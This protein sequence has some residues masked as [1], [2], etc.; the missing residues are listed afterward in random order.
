MMLL[1]GVKT[2]Y[3][4]LDE[5]LYYLERIV[6]N[7]NYFTDVFDDI[8][9]YHATCFSLKSYGVRRHPSIDNSFVI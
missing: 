5:Y 7:D 4:K 2:I 9:L 6:G 3:H 8:G 1:F